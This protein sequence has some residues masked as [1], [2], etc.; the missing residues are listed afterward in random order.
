VID[1]PFLV[2]H[3]KQNL[4]RKTY[5]E[6]A[7]AGYVAP[8]FI[9]ALDHGEFALDDVYRFDP[10][11]FT[12]QILSI[13]E[14]MIA[15]ALKQG[16]LKDWPWAESVRL[17]RSLELTPERTFAD[18]PWLKP[19]PLSGGEV[20]LILKHR[21]A[22]ERIAQGDSDYAIVS[23][24]DVIL[25]DHSIAYLSQILASLPPDFDYVDLAGGVG[26]FA[27]RNDPCVNRHFYK[28][29]PPRDRTSCCAIVRK[30]FV[31]RVLRTE[32]QIVLGSDWMLT[33]LF[34]LLNANVYW[35]EPL[36]FGH[37]SQMQVYRSNLI[38]SP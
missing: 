4:E 19:Q 23:E 35:A 25:F 36:V 24:D 9:E 21:L 11:L 7:L 10:A 38:A 37:G 13:K 30:S 3:Y 32:P 34:N 26:L 5:L 22:W 28:I 16:R 2:L 8:S 18:H 31:E 12:Q 33:Y 6:R 1:C 27:T 14:V 17:V 20:S 15:G 29:D